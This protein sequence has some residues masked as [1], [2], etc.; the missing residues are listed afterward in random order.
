MDDS[1]LSGNDLVELDWELKLA[2]DERDATWREGS[3]MLD[4]LVTHRRLGALVR[5]R[6]I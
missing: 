2:Y 4:T 5:F 6:M 1:E 3:G